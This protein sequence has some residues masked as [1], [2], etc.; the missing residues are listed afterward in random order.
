M[1]DNIDWDEIAPPRTLQRVIRT[2]KAGRA[3]DRYGFRIREHLKIILEKP[4][5]WI[6]YDKTV[7][8]PMI[9]GTFYAGSLG[10]SIGA[11]LFAAAKGQND[12]RPVQNPDADRLVAAGVVFNTLFRSDDARQY[13]ET[14]HHGTCADSR[15]SQRGLS[16]NGTE[17]VAREVQRELEQNDALTPLAATPSVDMKALFEADVENC[18]PTIPR[19]IV[20]DMVAGK[21]STDYP[22]TPYK[23]GDAL[24]THP[25]FRAALPICH[26]LYG[27]SGKPTHHFPGRELESVEFVD[28][29]SQGCPSGSPLTMLAL[30]LAMHIT[31]SKYPH[32]AVRILAIVDD[33]NL[34]GK[35]SGY[36]HHLSGLE[37]CFKGRVWGH[38]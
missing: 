6:L 24:P 5:N 16:Q 14:G 23:K 9:Q 15:I 31:L 17:W 11:Q 12:V 26:L 35:N 27:T 20:L 4:D 22:N 1:Q 34:L 29:L 19:Q 37:R 25:S 28:G 3:P 30:H 8:R 18:F 21:A 33:L 38:S 13:F 32:L 7:L 10:F 36:Y 2:K